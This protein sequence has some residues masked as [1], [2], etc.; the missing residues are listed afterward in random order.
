[1]AVAA[2]TIDWLSDPLDFAPAKS[3]PAEAAPAKSVTGP[4]DPK[5]QALLQRA[6]VPEPARTVYTVYPRTPDTMVE[7]AARTKKTKHLSA[8]Q[9][10]AKVLRRNAPKISKTWHPEGF[11]RAM[12]HRAESDGRLLA[13]RAEPYYVS[14]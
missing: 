5:L 11:A 14:D 7:A 10:I 8:R 2:S 3:A 6:K 1:M 4:S 13:G 12:D 9:R